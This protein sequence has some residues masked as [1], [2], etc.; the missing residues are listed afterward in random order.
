MN[1]FEKLT[2]QLEFEFFRCQI[3]RDKAAKTLSDKC[4]DYG[5]PEP[6]LAKIASRWTK[7]LGVK[8]DGADVAFMM[9]Q[10]KTAR[11]EHDTS[12]FDSRLDRACYLMLVLRS[13][14]T[15]ELSLTRLWNYFNSNKID[16]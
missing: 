8:L 14:D 4:E 3:S 2:E 9:S 11:L 16:K 15:C 7:Y 13:L 5:D 10:L 6:M 12:N 1:L